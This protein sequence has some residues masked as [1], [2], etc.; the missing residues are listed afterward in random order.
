MSADD[1][2]MPVPDNERLRMWGDAPNT[3]LGAG[4]TAE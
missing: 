3:Q 1:T 4:G 2:E